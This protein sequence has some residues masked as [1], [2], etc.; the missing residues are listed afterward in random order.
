MD[1]FEITAY[2]HPEDEV[3]E[4]QPAE[5]GKVEK[6]P[7]IHLTGSPIGTIT[8]ILP[9]VIILV[10]VYF[11]LIRPQRKADKAEKKMKESIKIGDEVV[12]IGGI[13]GKVI[14][15]EDKYIFIEIGNMNFKGDRPFLK[16]ERDAVKRIE[17]AD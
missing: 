8:T 11:V 10:L 5:I 3:Y 12:T 2:A 15:V 16:V 7:H 13:C 9:V 17:K 6:N 1:F 4:G 14:D